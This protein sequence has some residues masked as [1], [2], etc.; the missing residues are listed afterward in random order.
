MEKSEKITGIILAGG[1]AIRMGGVDKGLVLLQNQPLIQ[2]VICRLKPQ[3][4]EIIINANR[5]LAQYQS[6]GFTVLSDDIA[7]IKEA[8]AGPLAGIQLGLTYSKYDYV[9]TVPCDSPHLPTDIAARL[10]QG[11]VDNKAEVVVAS[12][13]GSA[14]PVF[15]LCKK[16][17]LASLNAYLAQGGRKVSIWQKSLAYAEVDFTDCSNAFINLNTLTEVS[18]LEL[19]L[20]SEHGHA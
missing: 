18:T 7:S 2:H 17:A 3:V 14:H 16:T 12:S 11:L 9:L 20:K 8:F 5:E 4:D 6:L 19:K 1:R 10:M 15:C 13:D